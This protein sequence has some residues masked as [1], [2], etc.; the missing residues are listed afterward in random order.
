M[1]YEV[2][3]EQQIN[4]LKQQRDAA[5]LAYN[6]T[7]L[8]KYQTKVGQ[9]NQQID[10][11]VNAQKKNTT[12]ASDTE[13]AYSDLGMQSAAHLQELADKAEAA[14]SKIS[15]SGDASLSQQQEAFLKYA[16]A[17]VTAAEASGSLPPA[18]LDSQAAALGLT[19]QLDALKTRISTVGGESLI[20]ANALK[21][22]GRITSYN[23]CYTKL[24]RKLTRH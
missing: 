1:L 9:L 23:V 19:E 3:T 10:R 4:L 20:T 12:A 22:M 18:L 17:S 7:G 24:L 5:Q 15:T 2:I 11:L 16:E 6:T 8:D 14:Y 21:S 13:K